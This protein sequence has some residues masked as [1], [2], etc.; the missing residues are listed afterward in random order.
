MLGKKVIVRST[1]AGVF[2]G[3]LKEKNGDEVILENARKLWYWN[4]AAAI[5][6]IALSGVKKPIDCKF[7]VFVDEICIFKCCQIIPTTKNASKIIEEVREW[8]A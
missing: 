1:E 7:T 5:E 3:T 2:F 6:E 8:Q 4:G